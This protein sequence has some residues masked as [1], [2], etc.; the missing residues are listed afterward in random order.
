M[1]FIVGLWYIF[2]IAL[3]ADSMVLLSDY[4]QEWKRC[5]RI[6]N[7][8]KKSN[9]TL[10]NL[11]LGISYLGFAFIIFGVIICRKDMVRQMVVLPV[12]AMLSLEMLRCFADVA[13]ILAK[14][15]AKQ[16]NR[17]EH[18]AICIVGDGICVL[19]LFGVPDALLS[20]AG[21]MSN[22]IVSNISMLLLCGCSIALLSFFICALSI[23]P[24]QRVARLI[25]KVPVHR[26]KEGFASVREYSIHCLNTPLDALEQINQ[27]VQGAHG[28]K[29]FWWVFVTALLFVVCVALYILAMIL[30]AISFLIK[31]PLYIMKAAGSVIKAA[32]DKLIALPDRK[33]V[34]LSFR[35]AVLVALG[36][37]VVIN[38]YQPFLYYEQESTAVL[39]FISSVLIIPILLEWITSYKTQNNDKDKV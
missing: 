34:I 4:L 31:C 5:R 14:N 25:L 38:R 29:K 8:C 32:A 26:V 1:R 36:S 35:V 21:T 12:L 10:R 23:R 15:S 20:A 16:M 27:R 28:G 6:S 11:V 9:G 22:K 24:L 13:N 37:T 33:V 19:Y 3:F 30:V 17:S 7:E 2:Y 39:E 18:E